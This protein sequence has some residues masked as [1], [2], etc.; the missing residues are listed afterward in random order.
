MTAVAQHCEQP[1]QK[2]KC[3]KVVEV[4]L[5]ACIAAYRGCHMR[6]PAQPGSQPGRGCPVAP[7]CSGAITAQCGG[8][9]G[10]GAGNVGQSKLQQLAYGPIERVGV[11]LA[12]GAGRQG[13]LLKGE[14]PT[15]EY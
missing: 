5:D 13:V 11:V 6:L 9:P 2:A 1:L 7:G 14:Y 10:R 15:I 4:A 12:N 3:R 8:E